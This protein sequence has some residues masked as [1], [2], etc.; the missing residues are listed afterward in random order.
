VVVV[1]LDVRHDRDLGMQRQERAVGLVGLRDQPLPCS[2]SRVGAQVAD[3]AADD[4]RGIHA[5]RAQRNRDHRRGRGLAVGARDAD[6]APGRCDLA[7]QVG[8]RAVGQTTLARRDALG[9]VRR[10]RRRVHDL[11]VVARGDVLG[12]MADD[13][14]DAG[15][16]EQ[17]LGVGRPRAVGPRHLRAQR[18]RRERIGAHPGPAHAD[19]MQAAV[20]PVTFRRRR[21][22]FWV[23]VARSHAAIMHHPPTRPTTWRALPTALLVVAALVL[24]AVTA[25]AQP[26]QAHPQSPA[27]HP[28][29]PVQPTPGP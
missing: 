15:L 22:R 6:D 2:P 18:M 28:A 9:V 17:P 20:R 19:Q 21:H 24:G 14:A 4:P 1:E 11:D 26:P 7:E 27:Q 29:A 3:L 25:R 13:R 12:A 23:G 16:L 5:R 8:A 10:D